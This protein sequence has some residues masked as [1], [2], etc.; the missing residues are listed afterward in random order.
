M[1]GSIRKRLT[2][3]FVGL[4]IGPLLLVGIILAW[5]SFITQEQQAL[6][7]QREVAQHVSSQ[8]KTFLDGL[9]NELRLVNQVQGLQKL[10]QEGQRDVL[11][12]LL[13]YQ[14]AFESLDLLDSRGQEQV[15]LARAN[16]IPTEELGNRAQADEFVIPQTR[17]QTYY[18]PVHF[19]KITGEPFITIAVPLLNVQTGLVD[20]VL[21]SEIRLQRNWDLIMSLQTSPGQSVYIVDARNK[22]VAHR[23]PSV[24]LGGA[25]FPVPDR[26]GIQPGLAS[27]NPMLTD[28]GEGLS[29]QSLVGRLTSPNVVLA[30]DTVRFG[31]QEFNI[32]A[33]QTVAE[34]L[35][36]AI[37]TILVTASLIVA[38]LVMSVALGLVIVRQVVQ[39]IQ[40]MAT[41][42]Q[43][44][45]AGDLSRQVQVSNTDEVGVLAAAF[46][47]MTAQ[48]RQNM[49]S[50]EQ[51]IVEVKRAEESLRRANETL[52][53]LIDHSPLAIIMLDLNGHILLWNNAAEKMYGWTAQEALGE[54]IS[55]V[56][57][58]KREELR[59]I[60]EGVTQGDIFTDLELERRRKDGSRILARV[61][62]APLRDATG[63]VYAHISIAADITER[64]K[65]EQ[66][67]RESEERL[68]QI[69]S[70]LREV[71]WLRDAQTRQVLYVNPA[72]EELTGR[73]CE[74]FYG[75][76]DIV[77]EAIHPDDKEEVIEALDQRFEG[78][79]FD[80]E[81]RIIHLDGSVRW[82]SS[83]I[84]PVRNEAGEVYRWASI[85]EDITERKKIE[86]TLRLTQFCVD[87]ASV[88]IMRTGLDA[89]ILSVNDELC[90]DLGYTR[91]ELCTMRTLD[92]DPA[93]EMEGWLAHRQYLRAHGSARIER[94]YRRK[95]GTTFPVEITNSY[96]EFQGDEFAF[97]FVLDITERKRAEEEKARLEEQLRQAHKMESVG[98]LAGGVAHDFNN[99]LTVILGY[100]ELM[101][102]QLSGDDSLLKYVLEVE[103]AGL[104][105]RDITRQLLA[106][107]RKQIIAPK[108]VNLNELITSTQQTL[109][110]LIG[111]DIDLRFYPEKNLWRVKF[112]PSQVDQILVNLAVNAR[113]AMPTGGKLTIETANVS[114]DEAYCREHLEFRPG[115]Y[116]LLEVSDSG[117]GMDKET[118]A[119]IFEPF[120]TTKEVGKGTGLGLATVYGIVKQNDSFINFYS[121]PGQGTTFKIYIPRFMEKTEII[122]TSEETKLISG[123]GTVLLVEDDKMVR[124]MTTAML[125]TI[126]YTVLV[127][128]TPSDALSLCTKQDTPIDLLITDVVM[129]EMSG[130]ELRDMIKASRPDIK[131]LFMSG[132]TSNVIVHH[133]VLEEG[134]HFI[135]KPFSMND[136]A[137]KIHHALGDK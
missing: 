50:L 132:Y 93:L 98:R 113:D 79:P 122:E 131:V 96:L 123:S 89:T 77:V 127:A 84:F 8:V 107:S 102:S 48:L 9:E 136:L 25:T 81:H 91:E 128:E 95:D 22:V 134:V 34:A 61:S 97:S 59:A 85:M 47:S 130:P 56:P 20:G 66:A 23:N 72:F 62:I 82:V 87:R 110:R 71:I 135:Q 45:S 86:N 92:I 126:G 15:R 90:R 30:V 114:L 2:L 63:S 29:I 17:G 52:Q 4:A 101:K 64:K 125:K 108:P 73:T 116:V 5:Q 49:E 51:Q 133:G 58:D 28:T 76:R 100:V 75:N 19:D 18:S 103:K 69:A 137:R 99:M 35:A 33:E 6:N 36:L 68:R 70:S 41:T 109:A 44:I 13:A 65:A 24:V 118:L 120:F 83:R 16:V 105:S 39:P 1:R 10:D 42:A 7:L 53:A 26:D 74:S 54:F 11:G 115:H 124:E 57:E 60:R 40:A 32:I 78:V 43:A 27:V 121:E 88:G 31:E 3:A 21:V 80:K 104:H 12:K 67:L 111:E 38:A 106:F 112:D 94:I 117:T 14:D 129:P 119:H 46:N 37:T 55:F